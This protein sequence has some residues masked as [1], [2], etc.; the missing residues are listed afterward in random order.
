MK[1]ILLKITLTLL[2]FISLKISTLYTG[3]MYVL[4]YQILQIYN[5]DIPVTRLACYRVLHDK[6]ATVI[7]NVLGNSMF[8]KL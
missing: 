7:N 1:A 2:F 8:I 4:I 3:T 5:A 6:I